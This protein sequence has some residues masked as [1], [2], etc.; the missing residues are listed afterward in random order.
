MS[1]FLKE[2]LLQSDV[3]ASAA[4][5][6][7]LFF[8]R[9]LGGRALKRGGFPPL[10][11]RRW[12]AT[13]RNVLIVVAM[14]GLVMIWAPQL[15]TFALSLTAFAVASV[16]A[17]KELI[18]CISGSALRTLSRAYSVG[19]YIE[20]GGKRGEVMDFNLLVTRLREFEGQEGSFQRTGRDIILPHSLLFTSPVRVE[21]HAGG[22]VRHVFTMTF[23]P[24]ANLFAERAAV[25]QAAIEA[26]KATAKADAGAPYL[27]VSIGTSDIGKQRLKVAF[28][29]KPEVAGDIEWAIASGVGDLVHNLRTAAK[30]ASRGDQGQVPS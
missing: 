13:L 11:V 20:I 6:A 26:Y 8:V 19:D 15:R 10:V 18:L 21:G 16:V 12:T 9:F 25:E 29:S 30:I 1:Q 27:T 23:E 3:L 28:R 2:Q 22:D 4:L 17:M 14:I 5:L 24:D 7:V